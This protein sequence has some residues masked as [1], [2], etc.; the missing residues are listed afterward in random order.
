MLVVFYM[1]TSQLLGL[2]CYLSY[3]LCCWNRIFMDRKKRLGCYLRSKFGSGCLVEYYAY[4]TREYLGQTNL[5]YLVDLGSE[6]DNNCHHGFVFYRCYS[7]ASID[8]KCTK[9]QHIQRLV[10]LL[11]L[12]M[13][14]SFI[15]PSNGGER[16]IKIFHHQIRF[17]HQWFYRYRCS[18]WD[19]VLNDRYDF[20]ASEDCST[21]LG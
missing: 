20:D 6:I 17:P 4:N 16:C 1:F 19:V 14:Q 9:E 10:Q 11:P 18:I 13:F 3:C 21:N 2:L 5:G 12:L 8:Y 7:A 15:C